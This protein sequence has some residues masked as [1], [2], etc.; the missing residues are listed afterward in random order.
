[1][2]P[3]M[4]DT[5]HKLSYSIPCAS[6]F[7]DAVNALAASLQSN[8][9]DIAR[10]VLLLIPKEVISAIPDPGGP[11]PEDRVE[12]MVKSGATTGKL[13]RRKPRLQVRLRPGYD[14]PTVRRAFNLALRLNRGV[15]QLSLTDQRLVPTENESTEDLLNEIERLKKFV[16][17]LVFNPLKDGL[18]NQAEALHVL[19]FAPNENPDNLSIQARFGLLQLFTTLIVLTEITS[20]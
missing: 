14:I 13:W 4:A 8:V 12:T 5:T 17:V 19:G 10:S 1:M 2:L 11:L 18:S 16:S 15:L 9:A 3:L 6:S 20:A 7:R